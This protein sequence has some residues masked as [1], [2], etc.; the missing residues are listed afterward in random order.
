MGKGKG[1][2]E[3]VNKLAEIS[4]ILLGRKMILQVHL[5]QLTASL[6]G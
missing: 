1:K 3:H 4:T 5:V 2:E 6:Q